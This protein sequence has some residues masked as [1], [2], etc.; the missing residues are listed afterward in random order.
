MKR[1]TDAQAAN[2]PEYARYRYLMPPPRPAWFAPRAIPSDT[3]YA[4]WKCGL[5][6]V[7]CAH[8][9]CGYRDERRNEFQR[10][11]RDS[12]RSMIMPH[13]S[14]FGLV[15]AAILVLPIGCGDHETNL[16]SSRKKAQLSIAGASHATTHSEAAG[17]PSQLLDAGIPDAGKGGDTGLTAPN[18][19]ASAPVGL[20]DAQTDLD[21]GIADAA[22]NTSSIV[23]VETLASRQVRA[24]DTVAVTCLTIDASGNNIV[25]RSDIVLSLS[26]TPDGAAIAGSTDGLTAV[27]AGEF[28]VACAI[29]A[30]GLIDASPALVSVLP[31]TAVRTIAHVDPTVATAGASFS[32]SCSGE[33]AFLNPLSNLAPVL[34]VSPTDP[35]NAIE[36]GVGHFE[37]A[38]HYSLECALSGATATPAALDVIPGP[39]A[40]LQVTRNPDRA[41]YAVGE[42]IALNRVVADEFGNVVPNASVSIVSDPA[43]NE[44][45]DGEFTYSSPGRYRI[46]ATVT[47]PTLENI[48]LTKSVEVLVDDQGP[49]ITCDSPAHAETLELA[50]GGHLTFRGTVGDLA[51]IKDVRV[52]G[53][54]TAIDSNGHFA[55][56]LTTRYGINFVEVS[57]L[58]QADKKTTRSCAFLSS[59]HFTPDGTLLRDSVSLRLR[60]SAIDDGSRSDLDS[61]ADIYNVILASAGLRDAIDHALRAAP[62]LKSGCDQTLLGTCVLSTEVTY[63]DTSI[64]GPNQAHLTLV[65]NGLASVSR[66]ENLG[67]KLLVDASLAG[68]SYENA[69]WIQFDSVE[70]ATTFDIDASSGVPR[71]HVR[72]NSTNTTL[73]HVRTDFPGVEGTVLNLV[74]QVTNTIISD[75]LASS[76]Q[77]YV[78]EHLDSTLDDI[79]SGLGISSASQTLTIPRLDAGQPIAVTFGSEFTSIAIDSNRMLYGM[80]TRFIAPI[81]HARPT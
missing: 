65:Q 2:G 48:A 69:G 14:Y 61:I 47:S 57:A 76:V 36:S 71:A 10:P 68:V 58:D 42:R 62:I 24:G 40:T 78:I 52:N 75:L 16:P 19:D 64:S 39:A 46:S 11:R 27:R 77:S 29:P 30:L 13:T 59:D 79:I 73:G 22:T 21:A 1:E 15:L 74:V 66:I 67:L 32:V 43:G 25:P 18:M 41:A 37:R 7:D 3:R 38:G 45:N 55:E 20:P 54:P 49:S 44:R 28:T 4:R 34:N 80:G 9:G 35:K 72:A 17:S 5:D 70:V 8:D 63:L 6:D 53:N 31:G 26:V 56:N 33:D 51:G 81:A 12:D 23:G 60:P 50:P